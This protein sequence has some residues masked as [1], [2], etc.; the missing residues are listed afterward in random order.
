MAVWLAAS[1]RRADGPRIASYVQTL[2]RLTGRAIGVPATVV[3]LATG[4]WLALLGGFSWT[5]SVWMTGALVLFAIAGAV[6]H[7]GL[8]PLRRRMG[9]RAGEAERTGELPADYATLARRWLTVNG[10]IL[11]LLA[12]IL[13]L[14][15]AKPTLA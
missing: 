6:W 4:L 8:I 12:A 5:R 7:W 11:A 13:W 15:I 2:L 10:V 3:L 1:L 9:E 14:M